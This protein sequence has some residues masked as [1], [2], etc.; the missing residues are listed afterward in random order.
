MTRRDNVCDTEYKMKK[1]KSMVVGREGHLSLHPYVLM[2][3]LMRL[4]KTE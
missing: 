2:S 1:G 3:V 4:E